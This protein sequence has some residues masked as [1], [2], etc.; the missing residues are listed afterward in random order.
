MICA[1]HVRLGMVAF[2]FKSIFCFILSC[3]MDGSVRCSV[4]IDL[5]AGQPSKLARVLNKACSEMFCVGSF[6]PEGCPRFEEFQQQVAAVGGPQELMDEDADLML[7]QTQADVAVNNTC[8]ISGKQVSNLS[9]HDEEGMQHSKLEAMMSWGC[10]NTGVAHYWWF[11]RRS[12]TLQ[13]PF[14]MTR[15]MSTAG[16]RLKLTSAGMQDPAGVK[17]RHPLQVPSCSTFSLM[18]FQAITVK[19]RGPYSAFIL[20]LAGVTHTIS[21][22][23]LK[24]ANRIIREQKRMRQRRE[25]QRAGGSDGVLEF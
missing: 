8:P 24:R 22:S 9:A 23:S 21:L 4:L 12:W 11:A 16:Q 5:P 14:R 20:G 3:S 25:Q 17:C 18:S 2:T 15:A 13:T 7:D 6:R 19:P 10:N 1:R